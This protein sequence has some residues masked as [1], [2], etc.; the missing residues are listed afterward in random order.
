MS[1]GELGNPLV[2]F[3]DIRWNKGEGCAAGSIGV[4]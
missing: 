4:S 3:I 2:S 1:L